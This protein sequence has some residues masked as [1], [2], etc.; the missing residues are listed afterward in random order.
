MHSTAIGINELQLEEVDSS[1]KKKNSIDR[2]LSWKNHIARI[3]S[4]FLKTVL[5]YK[6]SL[7]FDSTALYS[8]YNAIFSTIS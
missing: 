8:F 5:I 3:S 4:K 2:N 1:F 6:A 7:V